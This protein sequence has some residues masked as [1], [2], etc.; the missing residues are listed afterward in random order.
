MGLLTEGKAFNAEQ[1]AATSSYV[2]EHG[3]TQFLSTW[4]RVKD[5]HDD[6]LKFGDEIECGVFMVNHEEKTVKLSIR[7]AEVRCD[8]DTNISMCNIVLIRYI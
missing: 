4:R 7:S 2:R 6:E 3:I 8:S 5:I 1:T